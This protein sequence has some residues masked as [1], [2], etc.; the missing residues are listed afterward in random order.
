MKFLGTMP[1]LKEFIVTPP[2]RRS[3]KKKPRN[4]FLPKVVANT[5]DL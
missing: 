1:S 3:L 5:L 4:N 2:S